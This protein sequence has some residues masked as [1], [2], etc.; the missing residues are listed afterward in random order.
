VYLCVSERENASVWERSC[1]CERD[2]IA[3]H[4]FALRRNQ[5]SVCVRESMC[6]RDRHVIVACVSHVTHM[7]ESWHTHK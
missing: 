1:V 5:A 2:M 6:V 4:T 7:N 3:A